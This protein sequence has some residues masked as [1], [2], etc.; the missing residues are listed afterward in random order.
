MCGI[1]VYGN[2]QRYSALPLFSVSKAALLNDGATMPIAMR[3]L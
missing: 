3:V 1:D 2:N